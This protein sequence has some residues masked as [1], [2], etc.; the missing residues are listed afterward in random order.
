MTGVAGRG[1]QNRLS[2]RF[3]NYGDVFRDGDRCPISEIRRHIWPQR[4]KNTEKNTLQVARSTRR[5]AAAGEADKPQTNDHWT[6]ARSFVCGLPASR[7]GL[8]CRPTVSSAFSVSLCLSVSVACPNQ[9]VGV[10]RNAVLRTEISLC[11]AARSVR[12]CSSRA[13]S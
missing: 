2:T 5:R 6:V 3:H 4:H 12:C 11:E 9:Y 8:P 13:R 1:R 10:I 7:L